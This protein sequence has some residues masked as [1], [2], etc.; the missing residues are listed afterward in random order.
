MDTTTSRGGTG[1]TMYATTHGMDTDGAVTILDG[2]VVTILDGAEVTI[3]AGAEVILGMEVLST[4][5]TSYDVHQ[6]TDLQHRGAISEIEIA[7]EL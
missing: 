3:R 4:T 1:T 7:A 5:V 6:P 2:V